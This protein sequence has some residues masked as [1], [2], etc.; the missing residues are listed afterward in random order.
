MEILTPVI[1]SLCERSSQKLSRFSVVSVCTFM[2]VLN[3]ATDET[4]VLK[5]FGPGFGK[6]FGQP[7]LTVC[8]L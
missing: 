7:Y 8:V 4:W 5:T 3:T 2:F 6:M 1:G